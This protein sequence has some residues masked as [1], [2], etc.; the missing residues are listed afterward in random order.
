METKTSTK[1]AVVTYDSDPINP[2][3]MVDNFS[4][5]AYKS[6]KYILGEE[7]IDSANDFL[8]SLLL[9]HEETAEEFDYF[10]YR[11]REFWPNWGDFLYFDFPEERVEKHIE[12]RRNALL[13]KHFII[14]PLYIYDH[15]GITIS[16]APFDCRWDSGQC[17][18]AYV[19]REKARKEFPKMRDEE[20]REHAEKL[21]QAEIQEFDSY[22][23][24]DVYSFTVESDDG[25]IDSCG[26]FIGFSLADIKDYISADHGEIP[27]Y[28][29]DGHHVVDI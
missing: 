23:R 13:H 15:S 1:K 8:E 12:K 3:E 22:L 10:C 14:L 24:G 6:S 29:N 17:G 26:N 16:T 28:F 7:K 9:F 5:I 21:M 2:R 20:V 18:F 25:I 11:W 27:V 4:T 19:S